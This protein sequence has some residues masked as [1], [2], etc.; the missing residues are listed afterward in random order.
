[1]KQVHSLPPGELN[2]YQRD[3]LATLAAPAFQATLR[4]ES[5]DLA[6]LLGA[7]TACTEI[8]GKP[9][10]RVSFA[11]Q[12]G[13]QLDLLSKRIHAVMGRMPCHQEVEIHGTPYKRIVLHDEEVARHFQRVTAFN[14]R[15]PWEHLG[16]EAECTSYIRGMFDH[17]GWI[18][19][20]SS[21][22]I[23]INKIDG[24]HL[25]RDASRVFVKVGFL[26]LLHGH[27]VPSLRLKEITEWQTFAEK[28]S[29]SL[30]ERRQVVETLATR[31][32]SR[33][34]FTVT[35]YELV[36]ESYDRQGMSPAMIARTTGVPANSVR[37]WM[38]R[39]QKPPAVKRKETLDA[40]SAQMPNP[41][42]I[43]LVYRTFGASSGL[44]MECGRRASPQKV[45]S[46]TEQLEQDRAILYGN[47]ERI[48]QALLG[49]WASH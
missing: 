11:S 24:E 42:V 22:G 16:T 34:H 12:D 25:L 47:D 10:N 3:E 48:A 6:Y 46:F 7:W 44:A 39:G 29:L 49:S 37:D 20:G 33:N 31:P 18:C 35:D 32:H 28:I 15:V 45:V 41:D 36:R 38:I 19:A 4:R 40:V 1:M 30:P 43:N 9:D 21:P 5:L 14:S 2:P 23:G 27:P 8:G 17:G 13:R 26:P